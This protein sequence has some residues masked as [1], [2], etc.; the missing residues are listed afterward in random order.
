[1][2]SLS[3]SDQEEEELRDSPE[4]PTECS[5]DITRPRQ[6][7]G[8]LGRDTGDLPSLGRT[9][10]EF[11]KEGLVSLCLACEPSLSLGDNVLQSGRSPGA[12]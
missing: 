6:A 2:L 4:H 9:I 12:T 8:G 1:V 10:F 11:G 3:R 5:K 7:L